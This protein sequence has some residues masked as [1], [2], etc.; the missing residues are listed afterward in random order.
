MRHRNKERE[1]EKWEEREGDRKKNKKGM[2]EHEIKSSQ[3]KKREK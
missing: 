3:T 2:K 1:R